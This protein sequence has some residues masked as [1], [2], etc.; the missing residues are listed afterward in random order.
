VRSD[1]E[2]LLDMLEAIEQVEKYAG[3][4]RE[5]VERDELLQTWFVHHMQIIGEAA[6]RLSDGLRA[7][8]SD[9]P[10]TE[11]IGMRNVLV[12]EYFG[13]DSEEIWATI[14]H[15]LPA[16]KQRLA[17]ILAALPPAT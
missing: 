8:H 4:S 6:G 15:D 3:S 16:L 13:V 10:W 9:V 17:A 14:H 7:S 2:R 5:S 12:H 1:R 11:I